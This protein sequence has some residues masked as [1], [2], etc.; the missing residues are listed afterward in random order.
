MPVTIRMLISRSLSS[1]AADRGPSQAV[2]GALPH[3]LAQILSVPKH[4]WLLSVRNFRPGSLLIAQRIGDAVF[5]ELAVERGLADSKQ[6]R[7]L[8]LVAVQSANGAHDRL[9]F[10]LSQ[11]GHRSGMIGSVLDPNG[12]GA[13]RLKTLL[14]QLRGQ[15]AEVED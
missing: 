6:L 10:H 7:G 12:C 8:Q 15:V 9:A 11:G 1:A 5:L 3:R 2:A 14:L 13:S 4:L